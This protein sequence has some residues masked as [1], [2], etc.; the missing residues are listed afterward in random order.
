MS[1][2]KPSKKIALLKLLRERPNLSAQQIADRLEINYRSV[3]RIIDNCVED[4]YAI[5]H[6]N[7]KFRL[8]NKDRDQAVID[9]SLTGQQAHDL[10]VASKGIK[11]LTPYAEEALTQIRQHLD[12][13]NLDQE[14]GV[15]YHSYDEIDPGVYTT[16]V[17]AI[18]SQ[19]SLELTYLPAR[20]G[21]EATKHIFDPYKIIFW[22]G[23]Y[24]L[25]GSSRAYAHK[26][27]KGMMHLRL[28]RIGK[29]KIATET[30]I[31][32]E[33]R[34]EYRQSLS[35]ANPTFDPRE[36]VESVFGTFGGKHEPVAIALHFPPALPRLPPKWIGIR[37]KPS[38]GWTTAR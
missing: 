19:K 21:R 33:A 16:L 1:K 20:E 34:E 5:V 31:S 22:N 27:S 24:Y 9:F 12:G 10:L 38:S 17:S 30:K 6:E 26:P 13:S 2:G 35:F 36:Y 14:P 28:D 3:Y 32:K 7:K 11:T 8:R 4:G 25:V 18:R 37:L 29:I 15:Y 23:H